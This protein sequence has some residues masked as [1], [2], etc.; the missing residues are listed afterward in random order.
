M[1]IE[2]GPV[3]CICNGPILDTNYVLSNSGK[4][5]HEICLH[6]ALALLETEKQKREN[7]KS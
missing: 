2:E 1:I 4:P 5:T 7:E 6:E 3:C